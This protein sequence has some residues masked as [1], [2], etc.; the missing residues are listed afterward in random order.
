MGHKLIFSRKFDANSNLLRFKVRLVAQGFSQ[1][2]GEDFDQTYAPVLDITTF[3][4]LLALAVHFGLEISLMDV[5]IAYLYGNLDMLLYISPPPYFLPKLPT[6]APGKFLGL[7][8]CK[9]LYDLKQADRMWYHLLRD[10]LVSHG[11]LH[12]PTLACTFTLTQNSQYLIVAVYVE[13]INLS[14]SPVL[15]KHTE[16]LFTTQ[17]DMK[18][19]GNTSFC[20]GLQVHHFPNDVL[21]HQQSYTRKL[22]KFFNMD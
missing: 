13:D 6:P 22:L 1:R 19:L 20:L 7:R 18:L 15:C 11:F 3:R 12:D 8:I 9:A 14:G 4:Y 16:T 2:P 10:F 17:F 5:V 21:L